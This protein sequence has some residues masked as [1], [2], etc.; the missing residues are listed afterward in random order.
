MKVALYLILFLLLYSCSPKNLY[1]NIA[2]GHKAISGIVDSVYTTSF[3]QKRPKITHTLTW[4][5]V[6]ETKIHCWDNKYK[7][8]DTAV[9]LKVKR[10]I[11]K[12]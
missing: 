8:G 7:K 9:N 4:I 6:G 1:Q 10:L 5:K 2:T 11:Y 12:P 3:T